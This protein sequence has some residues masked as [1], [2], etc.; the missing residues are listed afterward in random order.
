MGRKGGGKGREGKEEKGGKGRERGLPLPKFK[1]D[2]VL[3]NRNSN[4]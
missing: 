4:N 3:D 2:Y 1:F